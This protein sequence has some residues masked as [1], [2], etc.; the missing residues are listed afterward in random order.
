[1]SL[2]WRKAEIKLTEKLVPDPRAEHNLL[3]QLTNVRVAIEGS[4]VHI[5][6][7]PNGEP[8][9]P[10]QTEYNVTVVPATS[11]AKIVYRDQVPKPA[12]PVEVHVY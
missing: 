1:M 12:E 5:D 7:R 9:Y 3:S 11:V 10:S 6:A 8:A 4:F 2:H